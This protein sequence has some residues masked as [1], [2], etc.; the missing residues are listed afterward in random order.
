MASR[1]GQAGPAAR[2]VPFCACLA[3]DAGD[4]VRK[5]PSVGL[6]GRPAVYVFL[7]VNLGNHMGLVGCITAICVLCKDKAKERRERRE[8]QEVAQ[9][10]SIVPAPAPANAAVGESTSQTSAP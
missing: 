5:H 3:G 1:G 7:C 6:L 4:V 8:E 9:Q 10:V 2:A